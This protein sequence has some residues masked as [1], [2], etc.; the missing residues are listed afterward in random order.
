ME[1]NEN[2]IQD[3]NVKISL[4]QE[5]TFQD[6]IWSLAFHPKESMFATVGSDKK[7]NIVK[8][9]SNKYEIIEIPTEHKRTIRSIKWNFHGDL[10]C[11]GSFDGTAS[12]YNYTDEKFKLLQILKGH[13]S[14]IKSVSFSCTSEYVATCSRD[15]TIWIWQSEIS[16]DFKNA[17]LINY[18]CTSILEEHIQDIKYIEFHPQIESIFF[19]SSYDN[20]IKIWENNESEEDWVCIKTITQPHFNTVWGLSINP[21]LNVLFSCGEDKILAAYDINYIKLTKCIDKA[22]KYHDRSIYTVKCKGNLVVTGGGDNKVNIYTFNENKF[23]LKKSF[24]HEDDVNCVD[25]KEISKNSYYVLSGSDDFKVK[26][27]LIEFN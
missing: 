1:I 6:K 19:S 4:V 27:N 5:I 21:D 7:L 13:E 11:L 2:S 14:E 22:D 8:L 25:I 17:D 23:T 26:L 15:K 10:L 16:D 12:I 20:T 3:N 24:L 18:D 9:N